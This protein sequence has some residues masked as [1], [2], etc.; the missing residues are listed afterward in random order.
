MSGLIVT[1]SYDDGSELDLKLAELLDKYG[2]KGT[3]YI[4]KSYLDNP[5]QREDI[6]AIDQKFEIGAHTLN[7]VDLTAISLEEAKKE[8]VGSKTY[9]ED[10]LG[11]NISMFCYPKGH[12]NGNI[13]RLVRTSGFMAARTCIPGSFNPP[14]DPYEW[15]IS[16]AASNSSPRMTLKI[17]RRSGISIRSLLDW[18]IRAKLLFDLALKKGGIYHIWGHSWV[19]EKHR[20]WFKLERVLSYLSNQEGVL[21]MTNGEAIARTVCHERNC[22]GSSI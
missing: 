14:E 2:I 13:K 1:T 20:Q 5:L 3:F 9:L 12:Y 18:E 10:L 15:P 4:P 22:Y 16:L 19:I 21:Y 11:H 7:H 17:W 8:I 6:I